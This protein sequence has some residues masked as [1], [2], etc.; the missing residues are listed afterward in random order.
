MGKYLNLHIGKAL[1]RN[2]EGKRGFFVY[3]IKGLLSADVW[4]I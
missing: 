2:I 1:V 3:D 4:Q